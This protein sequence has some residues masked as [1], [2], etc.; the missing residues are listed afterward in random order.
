MSK[1]RFNITGESARQEILR[2]VDMAPL[3]STIDLDT[4]ATYTTKQRGSLHVWCK[5]MAELLNDCGLPCVVK[6]VFSDDLI[7]LDW[8]LHL[9]KEQ[10]YKTVLE[11]LTGKKSTENQTTAQPSDVV[12]EITRHFANKGIV[13][14]PWPSLR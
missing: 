13:C 10:V 1:K 3:G 7:E 2:A 11:A 6:S 12:N 9:F 4:D 8:T 14:P 5:M